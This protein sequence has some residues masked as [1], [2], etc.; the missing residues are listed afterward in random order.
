MGSS[1]VSKLSLFWLPPVLG[2]TVIGFCNSAT[3]MGGSGLRVSVLG[4]LKSG[5]SQG[6]PG[7]GMAQLCLQKVCKELAQ[8][9]RWE[10]CF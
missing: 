6:V 8:T 4:A 9:P 1:L 2:L 7:L 5:Q 3:C 10:A